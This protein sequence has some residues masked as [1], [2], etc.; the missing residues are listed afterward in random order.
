MPTDVCAGAEVAG[1]GPPW[2]MPWVTA[3]PVGKPS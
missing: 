1:Y 3:T 2:C